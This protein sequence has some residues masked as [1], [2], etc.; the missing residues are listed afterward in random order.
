[1]SDG[2]E[3]LPPGKVA[4][5]VA[6]SGF[7]QY[8]PGRSLLEEDILVFVAGTK[9][10]W[11]SCTITNQFGQPIG[12]T[13]KE[14][15][16]WPIVIPEIGMRAGSSGE[17]LRVRPRSSY[18][19]SGIADGSYK[20]AVLG[21]GFE[22]ETREGELVGSVS[23]TNMSRKIWDHNAETVGGI[24][25]FDASEGFGDHRQDHVLWLHPSLTGPAR[26]LMMAAPLV[27]VLMDWA[28]RK[29]QR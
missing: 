21:G 14:K 3:P 28:Q 19:I 11:P 20:P 27:I 2:R 22:I 23:G 1:M 6:R 8:E 17:L 18:V 7:V 5:L 9:S 29:G 16:R 26:F 24:E 25:M 4:E 15:A 13:Y 10:D 12:S